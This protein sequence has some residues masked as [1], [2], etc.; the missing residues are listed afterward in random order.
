MKKVVNIIII[1]LK[2][3]KFKELNN[4]DMFIDLLF[5]I[6]I[7]KKCTIFLKKMKKKQR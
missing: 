4:L 2:Q 1:K 5:K 3:K 7:I 6:I